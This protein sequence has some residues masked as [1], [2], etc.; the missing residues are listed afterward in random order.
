MSINDRKAANELVQDAI[1]KIRDGY[2]NRE[3]GQE[4]IRGTLRKFRYGAEVIDYA[5]KISFINL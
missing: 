4:E 3:D 1:R 5:Q 2:L